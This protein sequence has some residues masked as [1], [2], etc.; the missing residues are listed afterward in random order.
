MCWECYLWKQ[1]QYRS[2]T[3]Y[4]RVYHD[5]ISSDGCNKC[6]GENCKRC[7]RISCVG[8]DCDGGC[9]VS[10]EKN[11]Y[12]CNICKEER[13]LCDDCLDYP[14]TCDECNVPI[15]KDCVAETKKDCYKHHEFVCT[16][17]NGY[18]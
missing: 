5:E 12:Y 11:D 3:E 1:S 17:C 16:R 6:G 14:P 15:C 9:C 7:A 18:D 8:I 4:C 10:C 13:P 2:E